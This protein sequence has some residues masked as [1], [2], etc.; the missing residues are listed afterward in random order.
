MTV[1]VVICLVAA[2]ARIGYWFGRRAAT[3]APPW[4]ERT[5]RS[6]LAR[7]AITLVLLV[8]ASQLQR[9]VRRNVPEPRVRRSPLTL[10][11]A[12]PAG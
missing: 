10:P 7:Q 8:A 5:R 6:A 9:S 11:A 4:Q 1:L 12:L 3:S 2:A